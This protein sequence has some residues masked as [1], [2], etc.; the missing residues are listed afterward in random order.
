[1]RTKVGDL[2]RQ[3][4]GV[5]YVVSIHACQERGAAQLKTGIQRLHQAASLAAENFYP[6]VTCS[7]RGK[8][9]GRQIAGTVI[10]HHQFP[11]FKGLAIQ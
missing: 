3:A 7:C 1:V 10:N 8:N 2:L 9:P 11:I 4:T 6:A 5:T